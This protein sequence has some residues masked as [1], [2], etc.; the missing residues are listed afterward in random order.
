MPRS[1][2]SQKLAQWR[3]RL[4]RFAKANLT[5]A[6]FCARENVSV[7]SFYQ[8]RRKLVRDTD[9]AEPIAT[10]R[11]IREKQLGSPK[12]NCPDSRDGFVPVHVVGTSALQVVFPNGTR[13]LV[14]SHDHRLVQVSLESLANA[15]ASTQGD[16]SC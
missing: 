15:A 13:V 11:P 16:A 3:S 12:S 7:P 2:N 14:P 5:V 9:A 6:K 8:W 1:V 4:R 10:R